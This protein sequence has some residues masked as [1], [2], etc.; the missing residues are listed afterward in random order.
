MNE[1]QRDSVAY[2]FLRLK[3]TDPQQYDV[4][5]PDE[6]TEAVIKREYAAHIMNFS[7]EQIDKG[8]HDWHYQR[9]QQNPD[10]RF[11]NIDQVV[12]L[13]CEANTARPEHRVFTKALP[14]PKEVIHRRKQQALEYCN[15]LMN[16][17]DE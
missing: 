9:Q 6:K 7:R 2:F 4:L 11:L 5:L 13:V 12:G 3:A 8:I 16:M 14:E 17:F 15:R 1:S 10:Y